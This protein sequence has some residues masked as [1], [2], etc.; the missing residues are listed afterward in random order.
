MPDT[1]RPSRL[2]PAVIALL[3]V[4]TAGLWILLSD[5]VLLFIVRDS[6]V[7]LS[8][9]TAKGLFFVVCTTL[10]LY[11]LVRRGLARL[12]SAF[13]KERETRRRLGQAMA[14]ARLAFFTLD[15][16]DER[17]RMEEPVGPD[18]LLWS[19]REAPLRELV[20]AEDLEPLR[21]AF[22]RHAQGGDPL[23]L[24]EFR[25]L[26][27]D[28]YRWV[29]AQG[30]RGQEE[31]TGAPARRLSGTLQD[32][33]ER[34]HMECSLRD[35]R[36]ELLALADAIP[37]YIARYDMGRS[38]RFINKALAEASGLPQE[39]C[40]GRSP[41]E[42]G[43]PEELRPLWEQTLEEVLLHGEERYIQ[44]QLNLSG[45][46][47]SFHGLLAP[48]LAAQGEARGVIVV[49]RDIT[50]LDK[51]HADLVASEKRL[52]EAQR[53]ALV[54][55]FERDLVT[56]K[57]FWS[58]EMYRLLG[59]APGEKEN[60]LEL[61]LEHVH[62]EDLER[63]HTVVQEA[64]KRRN[65]YVIEFRYLRTNRQLRHGFISARIHRD[66]QGRPLSY[67]GI[68]QDITE[69][70]RAAEEYALLATAIE[71][72]SESVSIT[73]A[74]GTVQY[75][76]PAFERISGYS[77]MEILGRTQRV[78]QSGHHSREFYTQLWET[79]TSGQ[80]W[81]GRFINRRK[82]GSLYE[83]DATI[84]PVR[85]SGGGI[86]NYV[87]LKRD[88]T[89]QTRLEKQLRQAQKM[90]AMGTLAGGVAHDFNNILAAIMGFAEIALLQT[91]Q[92]LAAV[93]ETLQDILIGSR[94]GAELVRNILTFSRQGAQ[95]K[96]ALKVQPLMKEA[97]KLLWASLPG[98]VVIEERF[99]LDEGVLVADPSEMQQL[100]LN[101]CTNAAH[102][103]RPDGGTLGVTLEP[104][105]PTLAELERY[106]ALSP[107]AHLRLR[108]KDTGPGIKPEIRDR[109][110]DP[111]F[112]TKAP[113]EGTGLGLSIVHGIV[114]GNGGSIDLDSSPETGTTVTV[115]LPLHA[116]EARQE[117]EA[118]PV[119]LPRGDAHILL[120]EDDLP[121]ARSLERMLAVLGYHIRHFTSGKEALRHL[122]GAPDSCQLLLTD[123]MLPDLSGLELATQVHALRPE[124]PILLCTG[125]GRDLQEPELRQAGILAVLAKPV[126]MKSLARGVHAALEPGAL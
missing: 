29:Q 87:A 50:E 103:M 6:S 72:A 85:D 115:L 71:Q 45:E 104:H 42:L 36:R 89:E 121:V 110:F 18:N 65:E 33:T 116:R 94:R 74:G 40:Q 113:G 107:G 35:S 12:D 70:K 20:H 95:D 124:L 80:V 22:Q 66:A 58:D 14:G 2:S 60:S 126:D 32:I 122:Q 23:F 102:A 27:Q 31:P 78:L 47:R 59:Y 7:A 4:V 105:E 114:Q 53:I 75:V 100:L 82:D 93:R 30:G 63:V 98:N 55:N 64:L 77:R 44:L 48:E 56:D 21:Q 99:D 43:L 3:Y 5:R 123:L 109:I 118:P 38:L 9:Q 73:D 108:V 101:L 84:S 46:P 112:T 88:V 10:L 1:P 68:F 15:L 16:E 49:L 19:S 24:A 86:T 17:L 67:H 26:Q 51:A 91:P 96:V 79:I 125:F 54:A 61:F 62:P 119:P 52:R 25:L 106:P 8:L 34:H 120:V 37:D 41:A 81:R 76:N 39:A 11:W 90:E 57:G 92:E 69:R 83:A 111:F 13:R 117:G 97:L 28:G